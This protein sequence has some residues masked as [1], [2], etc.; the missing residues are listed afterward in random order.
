M[1]CLTALLIS[2]ALIGCGVVDAP[3]CAAGQCDPAPDCTAGE[4]GSVLP[5]DPIDLSPRVISRSAVNEVKL[6]INSHQYGLDLDGDGIVDNQLGRLVATLKTFLPH[7]DL[8]AALSKRL[9]AS[10]EKLIYDVSGRDGEPV[11]IATY[12]GKAVDATSFEIESQKNATPVVNGKIKDGELTTDV[13]AGLLTIPLREGGA[14]LTLRRARIVAQVTDAG[15]RQGILVGAIPTKQASAHL[16]QLLADELHMQYVN[17]TQNAKTVTALRRGFD[18]NSDSE[19]TAD[20]VRASA[21]TGLLLSSAD[22]DT[23]NDGLPDAISFGLAFTSTP[24]QTK[25]TH[26]LR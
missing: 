14:V 19:I 23:D 3:P 9:A 24:C 12:V 10:K 7:V 25:S 8:Q 21:L 13:G 18:L 6:P 22:I 2:L 20:E 17:P 4:C 26:V 11:R 1:R 5:P 15:M 16:A